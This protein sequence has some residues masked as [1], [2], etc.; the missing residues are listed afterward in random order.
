[1]TMILLGSKHSFID[2]V[3]A[4]TIRI[5]SVTI[6]ALALLVVMFVFPLSA[7]A[8]CWSLEQAGVCGSPGTGPTIECPDG[9]GGPRWIRVA[10]PIYRCKQ[11]FDGES[12]KRKCDNV[13][14][15]V[16][17]TIIYY[18]C[19]DNTYTERATRV[20]STCFSASL[21]GANCEGPVPP[22]EQELMSALEDFSH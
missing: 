15:K 17:E 20:L 6:A 10:P 22:A 7:T 3:R 19:I 9:T 4:R 11:V 8:A 2:E 14:D 5:S 16:E 13:G 1:M 12:G 21:S 18:A